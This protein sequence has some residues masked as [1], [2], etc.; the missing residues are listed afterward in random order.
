MIFNE[1]TYFALFLA[2]SVLL[3]HVS[4]RSFRPW[5]LA[6]FGV[7]F[8]G[9]YAFLHFGRVWGSA[10]LGL[11][12]WELLVSRFYKPRSWICLL[13]IVQ[14]VIILF[15]FKYAGFFSRAWQDA[16][17]TRDPLIPWRL[18]LPLGISFF[19]FEFIHYAA[20]SYK[21]RI[22]QTSLK[23]YAA[24]IF[25][26]PSMVAGPIKRFQQFR[27][28]LEH[29]R[30][31]VP[32]FSRGVTRILAGLAKKHV[33]A[34]SFALLFAPLAGDVGVLTRGQVALGLLSYGMRIYL[35]FSA[36][37]DIAIGS[38]MLFGIVLPENFLWPYCSGDIAE[39]WRRWHVSLSQWIRDYIYIPL[40]GSRRGEGR[41]NLNLLVS[42]GVS[43]L[44]HG[45]G[46]NFVVWGL[47]H[48][49]MV[50]IHRR[51]RIFATPR[52]LRL[53]AFVGQLLTL[54]GVMLGWAFFSMD[55]TRAFRVLR[56]L[57]LGSANP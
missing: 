32:L 6:G 14:A 2:P 35:D 46:Y 41:A 22:R 17:A 5:V 44:W 53:P 20:D 38:G 29:A 56:V 16:F 40:G 47:W 48:G 21:D 49:V 52:K 8:F 15:V 9:W 26:F 1:L 7:A 43:G 34:D 37:S 28:E 33:L 51:W 11:F 18:F 19:T 25:F 31:R 36:Y 39:F 54:A 57:F 24:F 50:I 55:V 12:V 13:G 4:S 23:E 42:F 3:F 45:A 30:F 10:C 27:W